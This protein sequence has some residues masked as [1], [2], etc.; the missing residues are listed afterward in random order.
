MSCTG[1]RADQLVALTELKG[2]GKRAA[3]R[4][5]VGVKSMRS[6]WRL[7]LARAGQG[8]VVEILAEQT[9]SEAAPRPRGG[10]GLP[11]TPVPDAAVWLPGRL[12]RPPDS[13][14][15]PSER[16]RSP[17]T[18][19]HEGSFSDE[20]TEV[21]TPGAEQGSPRSH[22]RRAAS[23]REAVPLE[24]GHRGDFPPLRV[25]NETESAKKLVSEGY[26]GHATNCEKANNSR[27]P[28]GEEFTKGGRSAFPPDQQICRTELVIRLALQDGLPSGRPARGTIGLLWR[29]IFSTSGV[30]SACVA[31]MPLCNSPSVLGVYVDSP[32]L[33][34]GTRTPT[35]SCVKSAA[36]P[37]EFTLVGGYDPDRG[38][39][40]E[41]ANA[42]C[43]ACPSC[44]FSTSPTTCCGNRSMACGGRGAL[45]EP[46]PG[47][48]G[49]GERRPVLLESRPAPTSTTS[50][51]LID[52]AQRRHLHV[53]M[54]YLFRYMAAVQELLQRARKQE[55]G[56][57]YEFAPG[58][59]RNW[60][61]PAFVRNWRRTV[62]D[63]LRDGRPRH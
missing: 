58:C 9:R 8:G 51:R 61:V 2:R 36:H 52:L 34:C 29:G 19:L 47:A 30:L 38:V 7:K 1:Q 33:A 35:G 48:A 59:R 25:R 10:C 40:A 39:A 43:R 46:A 23:I 37:N 41:R 18:E 21:A 56:R 54:L 20:R 49:A 3:R 5:I 50:R 17:W 26:Y 12:R 42:G 44:A 62:W 63:V 14:C 55:F 16:P 4:L 6:S 57:V 45:R 53:Q 15:P 28:S 32:C 27:R 11:A 22:A 13:V 31:C 60:G 24:A